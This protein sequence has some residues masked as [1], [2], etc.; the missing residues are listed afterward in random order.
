MPILE[1]VSRKYLDVIVPILEKIPRKYL[2]YTQEFGFSIPIHKRAL[3]SCVHPGANGLGL[4]RDGAPDPFV[5]VTS[6]LGS[7]SLPDD[8][9]RTFRLV[10]AFLTLGNYLREYS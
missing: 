10:F 9:L 7:L 8:V 5:N 3:S 2:K 1:T 6:A 4:A